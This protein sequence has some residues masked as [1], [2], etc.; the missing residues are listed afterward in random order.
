VV[1]AERL[2]RRVLGVAQVDAVDVPRDRALD[3]IKIGGVDLLV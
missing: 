1:A 3:D 2:I